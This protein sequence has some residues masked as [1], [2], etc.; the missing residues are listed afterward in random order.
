MSFYFSRQ[1]VTKIR[2]EGVFSRNSSGPYL[3]YIT[4]DGIHSLRKRYIHRP[5]YTLLNEPVFNTRNKKLRSLQPQ[6]AAEDPYIM[7]VLIA[8]AQQQRQQQQKEKLR[9]AETAAFSILQHCRSCTANEAPSRAV[10]SARPVTDPIPTGDDRCFKV[11]NIN[12]Q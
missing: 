2:T 8:L 6:K 7:G 10:R 5:P 4:F 12:K 1:P 3:A 9:A 11:R